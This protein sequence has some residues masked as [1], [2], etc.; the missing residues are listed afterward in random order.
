MSPANHC[1]QIRFIRQGQGPKNDDILKILRDRENAVRMIYTEHGDNNRP[2]IVI[3]RCNHQQMLSYLYRLFWIVG[4]DEDPFEK[5]QF[6]IPGYPTFLVNVETIKD[7]MPNIMD[8]I[9]ST[10]WNWPSLLVGS[11]EEAADEG[12][13]S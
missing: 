5:V 9:I 1:I 3:T 11:P 13:S 8:L 7:K 4:L 10:C 6:F 2:D 12:E